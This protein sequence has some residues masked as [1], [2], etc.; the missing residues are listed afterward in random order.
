MSFSALSNSTTRNESFYCI[1]LQLQQRILVTEGSFSIH[2]F[3]VKTLDLS[4]EVG[5]S[6][7]YDYN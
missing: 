7:C 3:H 1:L 4:L 5:V 2:L 6:D